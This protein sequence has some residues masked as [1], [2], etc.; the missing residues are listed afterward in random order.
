MHLPAQLST[1]LAMSDAPGWLM[2]LV[3]IA[4]VALIAR[5]GYPTRS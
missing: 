5:R 2:F 3:A 4:F 1:L